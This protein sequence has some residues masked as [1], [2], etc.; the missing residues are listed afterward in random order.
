MLWN[1]L[2]YIEKIIEGN[3]LPSIFKIMQYKALVM[4]CDE[5]T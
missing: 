1:E 2:L 4:L 3:S 5:V